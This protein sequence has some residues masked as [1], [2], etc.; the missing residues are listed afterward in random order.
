MTEMQFRKG[1]VIPSFA[2]RPARSVLRRIAIWRSPVVYGESLRV[3]RGALVRPSSP[4]VIGRHVSVG[5]SSVISVGGRIGDFV[6]IGMHV[7]IIG[8]DD[9]AKDEVG[10]PYCRATWVFD[11]EKGKRDV[12][13]IERD[14]WVGAAAIVLSGVTIGEG[15]LIAAGAVVSKDVPAYAIV[16][17][18]PARVIGTRFNSDQERLMHSS[19]LN[20]R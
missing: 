9:H 19:A 13:L 17:G 10:V 8:R 18:N 3:S 16:A 2:N 20:Q 7:Q 4:L 1:S 6:L 15:A 11:R 12:V 5:R 14:V